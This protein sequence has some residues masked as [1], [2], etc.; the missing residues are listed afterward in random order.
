MFRCVFRP[1]PVGKRRKKRRSWWDPSESGGRN[2]RLG[3]TSFSILS[4]YYLGTEHDV[5]AKLQVEV[6]PIVLGIY[7]MEIHLSCE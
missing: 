4:V 7:C 3:Y 5:S 6:H 2:H 1:D